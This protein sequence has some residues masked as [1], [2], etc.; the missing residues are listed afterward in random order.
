MAIYTCDPIL[1]ES[2]FSPWDKRHEHLG[3][4]GVGAH[5][6]TMKSALTRPARAARLQ[7]LT[8]TVRV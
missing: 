2:S 4:P 8:F 6:K 1:V 7:S 5:G 3:A